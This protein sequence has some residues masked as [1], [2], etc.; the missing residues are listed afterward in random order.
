MAR[1]ARTVFLGY[2][3]SGLTCSIL[4][5]CYWA[6]LGAKV[7]SEEKFYGPLLN[8]AFGALYGAA[9]GAKLGFGWPLR[10]MRQVKKEQAEEAV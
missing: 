10:L 9:L 2:C 8:I 1:V 5:S 3:G 7:G 6:R 4:D